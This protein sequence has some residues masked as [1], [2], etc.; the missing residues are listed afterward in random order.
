MKTGTMAAALM[1][2]I[3]RRTL[4]AARTPCPRPAR[5][6]AI[7]CVCGWV[8]SDEGQATSGTAVPGRGTKG[9][10]LHLVVPAEQSRSG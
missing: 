4:R 10:P 2:L 5:K 8:G 6:R 7:T 1:S 3:C 9:N